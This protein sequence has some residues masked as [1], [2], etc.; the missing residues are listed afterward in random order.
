MIRLLF[1][2]ILG[3][4]AVLLAVS[5]IVFFLGSLVPGDIV[6]VIVGTNGASKAAT[7]ALREQFGLNQPLIVQ[8]LHWLSGVL[9]G[10]FGMSPITGRSVTTDVANQFPITMELTFLG[11]ALSTLIGVPVG[12]LAA[13]KAGKWGDF[14]LR[15]SLLFFFSIPIFVAGVVLLLVGSRYFPT[16]YSVGFVPFVQDPLGNIQSMILPT[17]SIALPVSAMTMQMTRAS[18]LEALAS[19]YITLARAKGARSRAVFY[20][21]ALKNAFPPVLT[22]LGFTFGILVGG[23]FVVETIFNLPGLGRG[24]LT[25][26]GARDYPMVMADAMVLATIFVVVNT[27]VDLLYPVFDPRQRST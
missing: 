15:G 21:H 11:L 2:R 22:Q 27:I 23:L 7:E 25:A 16:L 13:T 14:I 6:T 17:L 24:L 8:Y 26:I 3:L 20:I 10:D 9:H 4:I 18:M 5:A 19:P 12:V 1:V